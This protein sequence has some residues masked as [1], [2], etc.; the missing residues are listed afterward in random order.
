MSFTVPATW[1]EL[2]QEQLR[3]V[4]KILW[5]HQGKPDWERCVQSAVLVYLCNIEVQRRTDQ[6][7]MCRE[8]KTGDR[9]LLDPELLPS[10]TSRV[11]WV[12]RMEEVDVRIE[13]VGAYKAV[14]FELQKLMFGDYLKVEG[15]FQS[16]L[17]SEKV[18]CL[19]GMAKLLYHIPEKTA[20]PELTEEVLF[21]TFL[22]YNAAKQILGN[23]YP[24]FLKPVSGTA[25]PVTKESLAESMRVQI[26]LL[27]KGDVTKQKYILEEIDT[28]SA[29]AELD[30]LAKEA[31]EIK[32]KYGK[33]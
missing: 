1:K 11:E 23:E 14:D 30:A 19:E 26:R 32:R 18:S 27:T 33:K 17:Q 31:E 10:M 6:G 3:H 9:F 13:Q 7:W 29:L 12:T 5:I 16:Y 24:H 21:G 28:W 8:C 4:L 25:E 20:V 2:T 22:W 15:Y